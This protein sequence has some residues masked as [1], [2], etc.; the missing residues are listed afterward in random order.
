[1]NKLYNLKILSIF[2]S[3]ITYALAEG[4]DPYANLQKLPV[5]DFGYY[6]NASNIEKLFNEHEINVVI[7]VGSWMGGGSTKHF[8]QLL[9]K[10]K[11][12]LYAVDTWLGSTT[13]QVGEVHY[14][15]EL[16]QAY[17]HFRS[18]MIHWG[19][20]ETVIPCKMTSLEG[21]EYLK[22]V[23]PDLIY[24]DAEHTFEAVLEDLQVWYP[25][26][27]DHGILCGDDWSW[28]SVKAAV[29]VFAEQKNLDIESCGN[30]WR[31]KNR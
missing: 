8:A 10:R 29:E 20:Q 9:K 14:Q 25:L 19:Y 3:F 6:H 22:S 5:Y 11:G 13:Q 18:N 21:S 23:K 16:H 31:L 17:D 1:M 7:E 15:Q 2:T 27:N 26:L 28:T 24:V 30:F 4:I 12:V